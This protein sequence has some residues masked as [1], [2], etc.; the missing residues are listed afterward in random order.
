[1]DPKEHVERCCDQLSSHLKKLNYDQQQFIEGCLRQA[2]DSLADHLRYE[3]LEP[4]GPGRQD[5]TKEN[6][7]FPR[8]VNNKEY[9]VV[10]L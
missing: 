6:P 3:F 10:A 2:V 1:M 8:C 9:H 7:L 5:I 4:Q